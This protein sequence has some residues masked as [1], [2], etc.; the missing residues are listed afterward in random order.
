[1]WKYGACTESDI[2]TTTY[3]DIHTIIRS[4][5]DITSYQD[6]LA[7]E[8][9]VDIYPPA[10][11][12]VSTPYIIHSSQTCSSSFWDSRTLSV[13]CSSRPQSVGQSRSGLPE[14][15]DLQW[16]ALFTHSWPV[17]MGVFGGFIYPDP[18][19]HFWLREGVI[20]SLL[21]SKTCR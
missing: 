12:F 17:Y 21:C 11:I 7:L 16:V 5:T 6:R 2:T 10:Y 3:G 14:W 1:M 4:R 13:G 18:I 8:V 15:L 9:S 19:H 20:F